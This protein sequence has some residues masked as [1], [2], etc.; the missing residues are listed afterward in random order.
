ML[1]AAPFHCSI[2][3]LRFS[4]FWSVEKPTATQFDADVQLTPCRTA[5]T[6]PV[7]VGVGLGT[8]DQPEPF[9]FSMSVPVGFPFPATPRTAPTAQQSDPDTQ[10][11]SKN[12]PP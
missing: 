6:T 1:H 10:E 4:P 5:P 3:S 11:M 8:I 12:P 7:P 9:Q 2:T